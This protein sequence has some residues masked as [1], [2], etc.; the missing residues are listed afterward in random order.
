LRIGEQ[1]TKGLTGRVDYIVYV[2]EQTNTRLW[3][4]NESG[5]IRQ[6]APF[7]DL[8]GKFAQGKGPH[9]WTPET[10]WANVVAPLEHAIAADQRSNSSPPWVTSA[11]DS[12]NRKPVIRFDSYSTDGLGNRFL[13]SQLWA[14]PRT[15]LPLRHRTRLQ[16]AYRETTGK[17]W[18]TG[19]YD[20][21]A[22][23]PADVYALGVPRGTPIV[24]EVA[25]APK[26][27]KPVLDAINRAHDGFLK[28]YRAVV[29]ST[30]PGSQDRVDGLDIIWRDGNRVRQD[31]HL[32]AFEAQE[33]HAPALPQ[34]TTPAALLAWASRTEPSEKQLMDSQRE[35]IWRSAAAAKS[36]KPQ[37]QVMLH[38]KFPLLAT[39]AWPEQIQWPT[40]H[41]EPN[42][43]LIPENAETPKGCIGMRGGGG[44]NSRFD[45]YVDPA[46]DYVCLKQIHWIKR[47]TDW[48]K[49]REYTLSDLHRVAGHVV[50]GKQLFHGYGDPGQHLSDST[51]ATS[52][53]LVPI[54]AA[55]YPPGIFDPARLTQG[56]K[57]EGY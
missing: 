50:A 12:L 6:D 9:P 44:G 55:D 8:A 52:I 29:W 25:T 37:V 17:E 39:N 43:H 10:P 23:G 14:D 2:N 32:P 51:E 54:T 13:Y 47:G 46:N 53:D 45:Y 31:H 30:R 11:Q 40:R 22:T 38:G 35:Y 49:S 34:T 33:N 56:A 36:S 48:A 57:V 20:F 26:A 18:S 15:H 4:W 19:D 42:F 1:Y 41:Y 27:A 24:K 7:N 16:L 28:K 21:P 3:Y 5:E